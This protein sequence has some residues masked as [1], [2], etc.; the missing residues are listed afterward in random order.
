MSDAVH[1][2]VWKGTPEQHEAWR[3]RPRTSR[4]GRL[5]EDGSVMVGYP[6]RQRGLKDGF[7]GACVVCRIGDVLVHKVGGMVEVVHKK[8]IAA[9]ADAVKPNGRRM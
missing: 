7:L 4:F 5:D 3:A 2:E 6:S 9:D 8:A 1:S